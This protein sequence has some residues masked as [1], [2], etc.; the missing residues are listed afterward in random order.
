MVTY[1]IFFIKIAV[2]YGYILYFF[3]KIAVTCGYILYFYK[4]CGYMWL[5]AE[6]I[7][8]IRIPIGY[9]SSMSEKKLRVEMFN[10]FKAQHYKNGKGTTLS[11]PLSL[12]SP[13]PLPMTP[14]LH[15][16]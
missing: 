15:K 16:C 6:F 10:I 14:N 3:I 13:R 2:T 5:H 12:A 9:M 7:L 1:Y 4:N 11:L 8:N